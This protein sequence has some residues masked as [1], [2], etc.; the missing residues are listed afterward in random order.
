[1]YF[2]L[3]FFSLKLFCSFNKTA[4]SPPILYSPS[5]GPFNLFPFPH[6]FYSHKSKLVSAKICAF[7]DKRKILEVFCKKK[8]QHIIYLYIFAGWIHGLA[9]TESNEWSEWELY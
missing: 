9:F 8:Y 4:R 7:I 2:C 1:M 6:F 5:F 3:F